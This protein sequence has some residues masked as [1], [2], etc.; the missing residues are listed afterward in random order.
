[1]QKGSRFLTFVLSCVPGVGHLYLGLMVRGFS[2]MVAFFGWI[3]FVAFLSAASQQNGFIVLCLVLPILWFYSFFDAFHQRRRIIAGEQVLD[4][5]PLTE[6][7]QGTEPG[8]RSK[9]WALVFSFIPGAGHMYLGFRDQGLQLMIAFFLSLLVMDWL[10]MSF[11]IFI[12]PIIWFYSM[13]DA[14]Q[15]ASQPL[16]SEPDDFLFSGWLRKNHRLLA[17]F[18]IGMGFF[19]ILNKIASRFIP[20]EY[21][22]Y[23]QTAIVSLLLIG[24]GIRLLKGTKIRQE[25]PSGGG[26]PGYGNGSSAGA[27]PAQEEDGQVFGDTGLVLGGMVPITEVSEEQGMGPGLHITES[28]EGEQNVGQ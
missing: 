24:G 15:K 18:L 2:F 16:V 10:H 3:T 21:N 27:T 8:K 13:F 19:M 1:M 17:Y 26:A 5:S 20:W 12:I 14:L 11:M 4:I 6:L 25:E 22:E 28:K 9:V 7:T 23:I